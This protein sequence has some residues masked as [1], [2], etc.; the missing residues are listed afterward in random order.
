MLTPL[1][2]IWIFLKCSLLRYLIILHIINTLTSESKY[3][4]NGV[5]PSETWKSFFRIN[6]GKQLCCYLIL[7][8]NLA[9]RSNKT[10]IAISY[11]SK[12]WMN[13]YQIIHQPLHRHKVH[14]PYSL[15]IATKIIFTNFKALFNLTIGGASVFFGF[16]VTLISSF[17]W[18]DKIEE[19]QL[20][21]TKLCYSIMIWVSK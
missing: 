18:V 17:L 3:K 12:I 13:A 15:V 10:F 21:Y 5:N 16:S 19:K 9:N 14:K 8:A 4:S 1:L 20:I 6:S 2:F 7:A 11:Y